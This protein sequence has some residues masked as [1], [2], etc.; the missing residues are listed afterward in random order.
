MSP[1]ERFWTFWTL[2]GL[3]ASP[4]RALQSRQR[5]RPRARVPALS[6]INT[7][8]RGDRS[9]VNS[10][11]GPA[12]RMLSPSPNATNGAMSVTRREARVTGFDC[13]AGRVPVGALLRRFGGIAL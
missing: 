9:S 4:A 8:E 5:S 3:L 13:G 12:A 10:G 2:D 6:G 1:R 11:A 7:C